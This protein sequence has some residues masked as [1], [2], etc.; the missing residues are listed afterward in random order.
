MEHIRVAIYDLKPKAVFDE[1]AK[2]AEEEVLPVFARQPG[3]LSYGVA[4][5]GREVI[6]I[7]M[8]KTE[9]E[10]K[11]ANA[12]AA[13]WVRANI[14][15]KVTLKSIYVGDLA[16]FSDAPMKSGKGVMADQTTAARR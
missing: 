9:A 16:F 6:S 5:S 8:W 2:R 1:L 12:I 11:A 13:D 3:F 14:A 10:A 15:D 7:S 4:S